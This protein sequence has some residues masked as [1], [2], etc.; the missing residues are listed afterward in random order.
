[1][2]DNYYD[3]YGENDEIRIMIIMIN[4]IS[5]D[6]DDYNYDDKNVDIVNS[7]DFRGEGPSRNTEACVSK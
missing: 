4:I 1:M 2:S 7:A 6:N 3:Y 5:D